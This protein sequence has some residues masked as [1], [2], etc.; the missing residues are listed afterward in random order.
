MGWLKVILGVIVFVIFSLIFKKFKLK[1][2]N[3][4]VVIHPFKE[5]VID[6][7][8]VGMQAVHAALYCTRVIEKT[9]SVVCLAR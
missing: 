1:T 4:E 3:I 5:A 8:I 9:K 6:G 7:R 2:N